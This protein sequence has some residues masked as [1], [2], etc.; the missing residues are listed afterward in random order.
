MVCPFLAAIGFSMFLGAL[1]QFN[2]SIDSE[3]AVICSRTQAQRTKKQ[4]T[5]HYI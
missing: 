1:V 3:S 2:L 4:T 5:G